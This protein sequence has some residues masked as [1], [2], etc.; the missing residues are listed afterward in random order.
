MHLVTELVTVNTNFLMG[1]VESSS[2]WKIMTIM[3]L[4]VY[5]L[6]AVIW[7]ILVAG[8]LNGVG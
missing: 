7:K 5:L 3:G 4:Y 8:R 6:V 2:F 1:E